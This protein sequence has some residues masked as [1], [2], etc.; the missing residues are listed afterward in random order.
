VKFSLHHVRRTRTATV[1]VASA[2]AGMALTVP[3]LAL[4][5][6]SGQSV[7]P[8]PA[9]P[10]SASQIQNIDQVKTAIKG[11]Y[12]DKLEGSVDPVDN[13]IDGKDVALHTFSTDSSYAHEVEGIAAD[14]GKYL[15]K[16]AKPHKKHDGTKAILFDIDDTTLNTY[17]YEIYSNFVYN[18]TTNGAF[19]N[20]AAFPA[21]PGMVDLE[22]EA[23]KEGYTVFFLTGRPAA[24]LAGT[25]TNLTNVGYSVDQNNVYLKDQTKPWLADCAPSWWTILYKSLSRKY[26]ES[27]GYE[28]VAIFGD[29]FSDL[30]GGYADKTYKIPNPMYY[31]P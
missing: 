6:N 29:Q 22:Q 26:I 12:G 31:L 24:Q 18:P 10:T 16:Q 30:T 8:P 21:V 11:Y 19:V 25:L 13:S 28:I 20:A 15:G 14:A 4:A 1:A 5:T 2:A 3:G 17:N 27:Q 23:I 7:A 9:V